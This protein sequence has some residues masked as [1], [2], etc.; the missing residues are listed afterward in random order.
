M[1]F[2]LRIQNHERLYFITFATVHCAQWRV[3]RAVLQKI[4]I[5]EI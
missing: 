5:L 2:A 3:S 1:P 4:C